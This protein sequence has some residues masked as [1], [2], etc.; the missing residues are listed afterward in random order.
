MISR[1]L[2]SLRNTT[3]AA[4]GLLLLAAMGS[5]CVG[6]QVS[7]SG[8]PEL[9]AAEIQGYAFVR[10]GAVGEADGLDAEI[11][12]AIEAELAAHGLRPTAPEDATLL[13]AY[14]TDVEAKTRANDPFF[15]FF[16]AE[17]YEVGTL[18]IDLLDAG[19]QEAVWS[20]QGQSELRLS[21]VMVG[22]FATEL[23][24]TSERR[25]WRVR[26]KVAAILD[27]LDL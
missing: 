17:E 21:A 24:P 14:R 15:E 22:P 23:T 2:H 8:A 6:I 1:L 11:R 27:Q 25:E 10:E 9:R 26:R 7:S 16:P 5:S 3:P 4:L 12:G 13:I 20:G 19:T 18:T